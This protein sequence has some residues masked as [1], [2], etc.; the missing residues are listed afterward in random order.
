MSLTALAVLLLAIPR[1][2]ICFACS[3][4][5]MPTSLRQQAA[6]SDDGLDSLTKAE[7]RPK[8]PRPKLLQRLS[9]SWVDQLLRLGN[10]QEIRVADLWLL[11]KERRT[12]TT[13]KVYEELFQEENSKLLGLEQNITPSSL[14]K[15]FWASPVTRVLLRMYRRDFILSGFL[16]LIN[17]SIQ[18]VPSLL[19]ARLLRYVDNSGK[20]AKPLSREFLSNRGFI[21]ACLLLV[22]LSAKTCIENQY[23]DLATTMGASIRGT[24][25][26]AVFRKSLR[27]SPSGRQ[28]NTI[29][30]IVNFSQLDTSRMEGV[31]S[32]IHI[33][34]DGSLQVIGYTMLLLHFLGPA[35]FAGILAMLGTIPLN[36]FFLTRYGYSLVVSNSSLIV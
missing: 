5:A 12:A 25:S 2:T 8:M 4:A 11:P 31:A 30:E 34:W 27:L 28:N 22:T 32:S 35:V 20:I 21:L 33:L 9:F 13:T 14:L 7:I 19:I 29:G 16:K 17:T 26:S 36:T 23:F 1:T 18:F 10:K 15:S 3:S 24:L 6:V